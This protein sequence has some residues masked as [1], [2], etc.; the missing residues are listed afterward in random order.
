MDFIDTL[1]INSY[2]EEASSGM[3]MIYGYTQSNT[4]LIITYSTL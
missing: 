1:V 3:C 2:G 4:D